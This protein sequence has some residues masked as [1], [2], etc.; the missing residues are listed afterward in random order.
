VTSENKIQSAQTGPYLL[1]NG[2][3]G[4]SEVIWHLLPHLISCQCA[5]RGCA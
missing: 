4:R 2:S 3:L 5:A 1:Y